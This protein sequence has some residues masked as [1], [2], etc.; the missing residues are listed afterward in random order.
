LLAFGCSGSNEIG[1]SEINQA[2]PE[3]SQGEIE[4]E[5]KKNPEAYKQYQESQQKDAEYKAKG[6]VGRS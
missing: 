4:E 1:A 2:F 3:K 6:E 5:L